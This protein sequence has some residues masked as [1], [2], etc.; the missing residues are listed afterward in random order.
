[1]KRHLARRIFNLLKLAQPRPNIERMYAG[2]DNSAFQTSF[3]R[4]AA[5]DFS[6]VGS[7]SL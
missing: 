5:G 2:A 4:E 1:M 3:D 7:A 6:Q